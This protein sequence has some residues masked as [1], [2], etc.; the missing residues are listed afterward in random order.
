MW[1]SYR[2]HR[3][4]VLVFIHTAL[5]VS[6]L[7]TDT[8]LPSMHIQSDKCLV[9]GFISSEVL[10]PPGTCFKYAYLR[11]KLIPALRH[12]L[13]HQASLLLRVPITVDM[14][15]LA[16]HF[17]MQGWRNSTGEVKDT[18]SRR[19][20]SQKLI[21]HQRQLL[22][23]LLPCSQIRCVVHTPALTPIIRINRD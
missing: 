9:L 13:S 2:K 8:V 17:N 5:Q 1:T 12:L 7:K 3:V 16:G 11:E 15:H 6:T 21:I 10:L 19:A 22:S 4:I 14:E 18:P 23:L 20:A